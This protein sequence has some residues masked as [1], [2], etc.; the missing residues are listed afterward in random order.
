[1]LNLTDE[2]RA[3]LA[4]LLRERI[5]ADCLPLPPRVRRLKALL[6]KIDPSPA[7]TDDAYLVPGKLYKVTATWSGQRQSDS[8]TASGT[9]SFWFRSDNTPPAHLDPWVLTTT[10]ADSEAHFFR[11]DP[12]QIVFNTHNVDR[13]FAAYG[14][15]LRVRFT[16]SSAHHPPSTPATP[17]P[18]PLGAD[19]VVPA[20]A[21]IRSISTVRGSLR[22]RSTS[23]S[24]PIPTT[25]WTW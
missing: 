23:C 7:A 16:A 2:H 11:T 18:F 25:A 8:K 17:H 10:P 9:Q 1:M 20:K 21:G 5:E 19:Q 3:D 14:K 15:E 4:R 12:V 13:L 6:A 22:S 24:T